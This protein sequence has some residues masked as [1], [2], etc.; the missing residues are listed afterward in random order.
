MLGQEGVHGSSVILRSVIRRKLG[1]IAIADDHRNGV[2][3]V[4][5]RGQGPVELAN[6]GVGLDRLAG[7]YAPPR[8]LARGS[9]TKLDVA[10]P[11]DSFHVIEREMARERHTSPAPRDAELGLE[12]V[13]I[14][15]GEPALRRQAGLFTLSDGKAG[16]VSTTKQCDEILW[17]A[18]NVE[19]RSWRGWRDFFY[20]RR[21]LGI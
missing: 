10:R 16:P 11:L 12:F 7:R 17:Q 14:W 19:P 13:E 9:R 1:V 21:C 8:E 20:I 18:V 6:F 5:R 2:A 4:R 3:C 15:L